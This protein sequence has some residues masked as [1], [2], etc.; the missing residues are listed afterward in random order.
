MKYY[1]I[2]GEASGDLH[3]SNLMKALK[4]KDPEAVFRVWG[5]DMMQAAGGELVRHFKE[6]AFMGIL[7][8]V[9][10]LPFLLKSIKFCKSDISSWQPD[11]L[12][13]ID[14]AGFNL[15]I[16]KWAHERNIKVVYY[17]SPKIWAWNTKR[18][19]KVK[20]YIDKMLVILPFE[21][22][23][24]KKYGVDVEYVG[25]PLLDA[26]AEF[27]PDEN[28]RK[29]NDL[30]DKTIIALVPGSRKQEINYMLP[31]MLPVMSHY[32][33]HTFV[34]AGAPSFTMDFY[35]EILAA[36]G[37]Q[38]GEKLKI[39]FNSTYDLYTN[40]QLALVTS[41]T[42]TL[43]AALFEVPQVV[44]YRGNKVMHQIVKR[45]IKV[46]FISLV[47]LIARKELVKELLQYE[48][49]TEN[50]IE[51]ID[52]LLDVEKANTLKDGYAALKK[53][54]GPPGVADR[55]AKYIF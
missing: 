47:N 3:G 19:Y 54:M 28:F 17:I 8:V 6:M 51:E 34:I 7:A 50:L 5:G 45:L 38:W 21:K 14:Y 53:V 44:C 26:I 22:D 31:V 18:V 46:D 36:N 37:Y 33:N 13:L 25:N 23:F 9:K 39:V 42:A 20:K 24:Y 55:A 35:E 43:E 40:S 27:V 2:A 11:V 41:G 49:N 32:P 15:R 1:I 10:N 16:A 48:F 29:D 4:R 52:N 12:V 30:V